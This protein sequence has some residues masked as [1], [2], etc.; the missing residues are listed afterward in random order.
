MDLTPYTAK[1]FPG[2]F[3]RAMADVPVRGIDRVQAQ[4][5]IRLCPETESLLYGT[6]SPTQIRYRRGTRPK[7]EAIAYSFTGGSPDRAKM[8]MDWVSRHVIHAHFLGPLAADR[9][10]TEEQLIESRAGWCNEQVRVF[11]ALCEVL[12]IP[13]RLVFLFHKSARTAHTAAEIFLNGKWAFHDVTYK[14]CVTLPDASLA[15]AREL[16][17]TYRTLAHAAYCQPM[18]DYYALGK[19][20]PSQSAPDPRTGGDYLESIGICNYLIEGVEAV[21]V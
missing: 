18:L 14:V 17:G 1:G 13:G 2:D 21:N 9:A 20:P 15:E 10:M 12:E 3:D 16:N 6:F 7:L 5:M 19:S 4:S 8:A 11:I